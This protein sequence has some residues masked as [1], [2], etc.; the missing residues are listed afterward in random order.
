MN[1]K[2]RS[3]YAA[4][5]VFSLS[6]ACT[7]AAFDRTFGNRIAGAFTPAAVSYGLH[8]KN[9]AIS[10]H[11]KRTLNSH[12]DACNT[13]TVSNMVRHNMPTMIVFCGIALAPFTERR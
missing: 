2:A 1:K 3:F 11:I 5:F 13:Q 7:G 12:G 8:C 9:A 4:G 10:D 6:L